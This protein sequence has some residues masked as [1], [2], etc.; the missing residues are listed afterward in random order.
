MFVHIPKN[1]LKQF[2]KPT[3]LLKTRLCIC[4]LTMIVPFLFIC[5]TPVFIIF[6]F[7]YFEYN[8]RK[9]Q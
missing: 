5:F 4:C 9:Q 7:F 8:I 3:D 1:A 6:P 2:L